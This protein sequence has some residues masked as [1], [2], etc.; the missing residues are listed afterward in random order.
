MPG[1]DA[2]D[3]TPA[4]NPVY[5]TGMSGAPNTVRLFALAYA[6]PKNGENYFYVGEG[7]GTRTR[8]QFS[9]RTVIPPVLS[10]VHEADRS[11]L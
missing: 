1:L 8:R 4:L 7:K 2:T 11:V 10:P 5:H 6:C 9:G 3:R